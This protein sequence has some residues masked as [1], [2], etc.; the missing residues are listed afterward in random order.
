MGTIHSPRGHGHRDQG[1]GGNGKGDEGPEGWRGEGGGGEYRG[2]H[3]WR[4]GPDPCVGSSRQ[5]SQR[6]HGERGGCGGDH[7]ACKGQD[8]C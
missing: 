8:A 6:E 7:C 4:G 2:T 1:Q 3:K 5:P